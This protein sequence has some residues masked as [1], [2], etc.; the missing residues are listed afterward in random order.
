MKMLF[1]IQTYIN[2]WQNCHHLYIVS[3]SYFGIFI[4]AEG[5]ESNQKKILLR[6]HLS[7][8]VAKTSKNIFIRT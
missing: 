1:I 7:Q 6:S 2:I 3:T 4:P 8:K 5:W